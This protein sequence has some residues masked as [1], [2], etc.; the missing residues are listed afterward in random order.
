MATEKEM[1]AAEKAAQKLLQQQSEQLAKTL[2]GDFQALLNKEEYKTISAEL[3]KNLTEELSH[4]VAQMIVDEFMHKLQ[5]EPSRNCN[6]AGIY[7]CKGF[8]DCL[9]AYLENTHQL[10]CES[11]VF[12]CENWFHCSS[13]FTCK[14]TFN[15]ADDCEEHFVCQAKK[16]GCRTG[17]EPS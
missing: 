17:Y 16:F 10:T 7:D 11:G 2:S 14:N 12:K 6:S 13:M 3:R 4:S 1:M 8:Y 9:V 15:E 5:G